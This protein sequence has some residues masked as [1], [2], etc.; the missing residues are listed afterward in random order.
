MESNI[1]DKE[2]KK[3]RRERDGS[4]DKGK[5]RERLKEDG[6]RWLGLLRKKGDERKGRNGS[7]DE[8]RKCVVG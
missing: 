1:N 8:E 3:E 7:E 6:M 2:E 5:E 4:R